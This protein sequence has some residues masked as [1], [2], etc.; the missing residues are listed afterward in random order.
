MNAYT[1]DLTSVLNN[2]KEL[3]N[4]NGL[5]YIGTETLLYSILLTKKCDAC[6]YLNEFGANKDNFIPHYRKTIRRLNID[7]YTP[8]ASS[9]LYEANEISSSFRNTYI[10]TEHLLMAI[11]RINDCNG[12][13]ILRALG[14]D[15]PKLYA[16]IFNS[17]KTNEYKE[18]VTTHEKT[19]T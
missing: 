7:G 17:L 5:T 16:T 14:V 18:L 15:I 11:L 8:K 6:V 2:A 12:V 13:K 3:Q 9:A 19:R 1:K 4:N 10:S